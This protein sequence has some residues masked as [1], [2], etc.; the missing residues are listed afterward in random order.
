MKNV[1]I[2]K[3]LTI[4]G[5]IAFAIMGFFAIA[6]F[7]ADIRVQTSTS[8]ILSS[9]YHGYRYNSFF[10]LRFPCP[11]SDEDIKVHSNLESVRNAREYVLD[12]DPDF[13]DCDSCCSPESLVFPIDNYIYYYHNDNQDYFYRIN[14]DTGVIEQR[15]YSSFVKYDNGMHNFSVSNSIIAEALIDYYSMSSAIDSINGMFYE[16]DIYYCDGRIFFEKSSRL[17]EYIPGNDIV[18]FIGNVGESENIVMIWS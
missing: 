13:F 6:Y 12:N 15:E 5:I 3:A 16:C 4:I 14:T 7:T 11:L 18:R 10:K 17:Y 1:N 2:K 8:G 9:S